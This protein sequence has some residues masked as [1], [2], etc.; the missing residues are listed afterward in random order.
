[1]LH[2]HYPSH[3]FSESH[4]FEP[5]LR[6]QQL[7]LGGLTEHVQSLIDQSFEVSDSLPDFCSDPEIR[8]M[9]IQAEQIARTYS[10]SLP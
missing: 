4:L 1:M 3:S 7:V 5:S 9:R 2:S 10:L 8:R 6:A